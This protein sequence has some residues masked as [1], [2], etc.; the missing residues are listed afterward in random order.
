M[1]VPISFFKFVTSRL[2]DHK[3]DIDKE[4]QSPYRQL[5]STETSLVYLQGVKFRAIDNDKSRFRI[6]LYLSVVFSTV[7][8][9]IFLKRTKS[10][11]GICRTTFDEFKY[12][13]F[14]R[15][16]FVLMYCFHRNQHSYLVLSKDLHLVLSALGPILFT[17]CML[18]LVDIGKE[19]TMQ[20]IYSL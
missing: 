10:N 13:L 19:L 11:P 18:H 20:Y 8:H 17:N 12:Y 6:M 1:F 5:N 2:Q 3:T 4:I 16:Q 15:S 14:G 9:S 7:D